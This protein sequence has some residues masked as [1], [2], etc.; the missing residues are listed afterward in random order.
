[1]IKLDDDL[2]Q[3]LGLAALPAEEKKKLLAH[4]YETL[5]MRVGMKLAEQMSDAQLTEFEQFIDRNDEAGALKWLETNFP[6]YKDVVAA[7]FERLKTEIR[8][9]APQILAAG[10]QQPQ[11]AGSGA[12]PEPQQ[13]WSSNADQ[14]PQ[15]GQQ[16]GQHGDG[17]SP[18]PSNDPWAGQNFPSPPPP[19]PQM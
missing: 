10:N 6:N 4:I 3:E 9:V 5:E 13:P 7:E 14:Q 17:Q 16:H 11:Q 18:Q 8:Q 15:H 12:A 2:L 1:M 19:P